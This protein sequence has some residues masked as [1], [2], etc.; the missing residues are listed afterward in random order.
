MQ[1][2]GS[3]LG[4]ATTESHEQSMVQ[5]GTAEQQA[6]SQAG[7][8]LAAGAAGTAVGSALAAGALA[9][10]LSGHTG[11]RSR[12]LSGAAAGP[13][14]SPVSLYDLASPAPHAQPKLGHPPL[15]RPQQLFGDAGWEGAATAPPSSGGQR[16][17]P[18]S[19]HSRSS[20]LGG[21]ATFEDAHDLAGAPFGSPQATRGAGRASGSSFLELEEGVGPLGSGMSRS[22]VRQLS[23]SSSSAAA[24]A[25]AAAPTLAGSAEAGS[26]GKQQHS[27]SQQP[28][29]WQG[30]QGQQHAEQQL[31]T[32]RWQQY[33]QQPPASPYEQPPAWACQSAGAEAQPLPQHYLYP[34]VATPPPQQQHGQRHHEGLPATAAKQPPPARLD[35]VSA[36]W[37][38]YSH[39][40]AA[41][42]AAACR[43]PPA[44]PLPAVCRTS[45][46]SPL[47]AGI[48][49]VQRMASMGHISTPPD[50]RRTSSGSCGGA[51]SG[52]SW[53]GSGSVS[54]AASPPRQ[55]PAAGTALFADLAQQAVADACQ[56]APSRHRT[57]SSC[58]GPADYSP[59]RLSSTSSSWAEFAEA[60][61][62]AYTGNPFEQLPTSPWPA[63]RQHH[64]APQHS[65]P[66]PPP[67][68]PQRQQQFAEP[69][70]LPK[71][72]ART[73]SSFGEFAGGGVLASQLGSL[74]LT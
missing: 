5:Q 45:A 40:P 51:G 70:P 35:G 15:P 34:A 29:G 74:Q 33:D 59:L 62:P 16:T 17:A 2:V 18:S 3:R 36:G 68:Q 53:S 25:L 13:A 4:T 69:G 27:Q 65:N 43:A 63:V 72:T 73:S 8:M 31:S 41:G 28:P 7:G 38:P 48:S 60:P 66:T 22:V 1:H 24:V 32:Q 21:W 50:M 37:L 71:L 30:W 11:A 23:H 10:G 19:A 57:S 64:Q 9:Q 20:S 58:G 42:S 6:S 26:A 49:N 39:Q 67:Q 55:A 52:V 14:A 47:A 46:H 44:Q 56:R 12:R 54:G 61:A